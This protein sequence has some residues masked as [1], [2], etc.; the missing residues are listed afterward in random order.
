MLLEL[1]QLPPPSHAVAVLVTARLYCNAID[2][3]TS[4]GLLSNVPI[5]HLRQH[6]Y[7]YRRSRQW[8]HVKQEAQP[9]LRNRASAKYFFVAKLLS[10]AVMT[11]SYVYHLQSLHLMIRLI[12]DAHS[13]LHATAARAHGA[14]PHCRL[15][16]LFRVPLRI[17]A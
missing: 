13:F 8:L 11:C 9:P 3:V 6:S 1:L 7:S 14:R 10:I 2:N 5:L 4:T 17:P 12:Y 16:S 15:M